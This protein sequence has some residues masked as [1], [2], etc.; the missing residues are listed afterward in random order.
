MKQSLHKIRWFIPAGWLTGILL[1]ISLSGFAQIHSV[2]GKITSADDGQVL[3]GATVRIRGNTNATNANSQGQYSISAR[4]GDVLVIS[5]IGYKQTERTVTSGST[6]NIALT[7]INNNLNEVVVI[8]YGTA[9][10]KDLTGSVASVSAADIQK[11]VSTTFDQALQGRVAGV[12]IMQNS[13]QPGAGVSIQVRGLGSINAGIDPLYVIDGVI[14]PPGQPS[15]TGGIYMGNSGTRDNPLSTINPN[16]IASIDVLKDASAIAIYG[17]Q[18]SNGVIIITTKRGKIGAPKITFD[19]YYGVQQ[20]PKDLPMMNLPQYATFLNARATVT[21]ATPNPDFVNPRY[22]GPGTNWQHGIFKN[23]GMFNASLAVSGGDDKT[24]YYIGSSFL[25]QDGIVLSSNFKRSSFKINLDNKTNRWLRIGTSLTFS[26]IKEN[27]NASVYD[28]INATLNL[29][30]NVAPVNPDGS[31][32]AIVVPGQAVAN[33]YNPNPIAAAAENTNQVQ[34]SQAYG[35]FYGDIIFTKDLKLHNEVTGN[36]DYGNVNQFYPTFVVNGILNPINSASVSAVNNKSFTVRNYFSYDHYGKK[37][38]V[39]A[40][41]GHESSNGTYTYLSGGRTGFF[42][43]NP[44][45][46]SL[47]TATTASNSGGS[48]TYSNES[49]LARLTAGYEYKYNLTGTYRFDGNSNFSQG[50]RWVGTY[51]L[52]ASWSVEKENFLKDIKAINQLKFRASYGL[53]NNASLPAYT[54]G[55]SVAATTVGLGQGAYV[56]NIANPNIRWETSKSLDAGLDLSLFENRVQLTADAYSRKTDNLLLQIPL[57]GYAGTN[58]AGSLAAPW[59]NVGSIQNKGF[60]FL[61]STKNIQSSHFTWTSALTFSLNRNKILTLNTGSDALYG[62][63]NNASIITSKTGA[64]SSIGDFY[65]YIAQGVFKNAADLKN[66]ALPSGSKIDYTQGI[67]VGDTKYKDLNKDGVIDASDMTRLGSPLPKFTYGFNNTFNF[68]SFDLNLFFTGSYGNKIL[69]YNKVL[70]EDP[71]GA[72]GGYFKSLTNYA[73]VAMINPAGSLTDVNNVYVTNPN[74][75]VPGFRVS[76]D[77]DQNYRIS[78]RFVENGSYLRLKNI[79]LGYN[80]PTAL[81]TRLHLHSLRIY[82]NIQNL[83]TIT[84]YSGYDPEIGTNTPNQSGQGTSAL[85]AG[86]DWGRYPT[87]RIYTFGLNVGL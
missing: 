41:A 47:G 31:I 79:S 38:N 78:S 53:T 51:A 87:P 67:W 36:F 26:A 23:A 12:Q 7:G 1:L 40:T 52:G 20:L 55:S 8:G 64:G 80:F 28:L 24:T 76:G 44:Q 69:N 50:H 37:F 86:I 85:T 43:N 2:T 48:S 3:P 70:H 65:G 74:T 68:F 66:S 16:D 54:Y 77:P 35:N 81:V 63:I 62:K 22:L 84:K 6:L 30:P 58:G 46:L 34:R 39:N 11:T 15:S 45:D 75:S 57:P 71:N 4:T 32:G 9:R 33:T 5:F 60:E 29:P 83:L 49:Y 72:A 56:L 17:S 14:I 19:T 25:N 10:R 42:A 61:L 27:V 21:G 13:G 82:S 59:G 18:G 73:H